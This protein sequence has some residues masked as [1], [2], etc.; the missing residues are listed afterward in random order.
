MQVSR[1]VSQLGTF[2]FLTIQ[3]LLLY[4]KRLKR[5]ATV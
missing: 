4:Q 2:P 1:G 5:Q 3:S